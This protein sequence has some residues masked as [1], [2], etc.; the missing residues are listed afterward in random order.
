MV[1]DDFSSLTSKR[2]FITGGEVTTRNTQ[3]FGDTDR[4]EEI[5]THDEDSVC[6][7]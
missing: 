7:L 4:L 2:Y 5:D 1:G 6:G 3:E